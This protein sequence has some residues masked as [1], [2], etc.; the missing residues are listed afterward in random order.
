[1]SMS[2]DLMNKC[3]QT[4]KEQTT[5]GKPLECC[6]SSLDCIWERLLFAV[7]L[8]SHQRKPVGPAAEPELIRWKNELVCCA[9]I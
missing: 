2:C 8:Q 6:S 7:Q 1:M 5:V 3:L 4:I 9:Q